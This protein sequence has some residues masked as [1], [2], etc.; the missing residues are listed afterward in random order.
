MTTATVTRQIKVCVKT[1]G[2]PYEIV[3]VTAAPEWPSW[4]LA[5]RVEYLDI[6]FGRNHWSCLTIWTNNK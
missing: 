6:L 4:N 3:D 5:K 1:P 2:Q